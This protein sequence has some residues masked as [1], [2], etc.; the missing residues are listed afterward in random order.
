MQDA[1]SRPVM[2]WDEQGFIAVAVSVTRLVGWESSGPRDCGPE[3]KRWFEGGELVFAEV[4]LRGKKSGL[5][6]MGTGNGGC[7]SCG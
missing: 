2:C 5:V 4:S 6:Q 1:P 7:C 3:G